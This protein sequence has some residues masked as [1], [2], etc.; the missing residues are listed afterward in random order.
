MLDNGL[1]MSPIPDDI[2]YVY[3]QNYNLLGASVEIFS[4]MYE[5]EIVT[6]ARGKEVFSFESIETSSIYQHLK[7]ENIISFG[8]RWF[9]IKYAQDVE[10]TKGLTKFTCYALWYELAEGLPRPLKHVATTVGSVAQD[11]IKDAGKWVQVVCPPDGANKSVRS[12][13]A[14]ENSMLWHLR[15]L[16]KQY[17]LEITFGYEELLEQEVRIVRTVV[18][19]Q[20]YT[21]SKVDFPLVVEENLKYVTRQEDSRNL[22]TAYKL[23]GKKEEGSQEPLTFASIN[24]GSDYLIDVSWFTARQMRPRYIAKSKSDERFKIKENLMSAARAYL[25]IYCRPLIG[26]EASAVL[27]KK[28]PDLHHTQ[29]IVDDHYS[30]IEWRKIS[31]RKIDYDDLSQS[32]L[33]FQDPRRDLMDLLNEDGEGVLAGE[34]ETESHVVIRYADDILGTNFNAESGKY[35]GVI[36]TTKHSNELVP[37]DFTWVKLQGPE[38][39]QGEQGS[40]GRDGVDGVAGKNGVGIADTSITYAVSVSGTQEPENGWSE[41]VPE[42]IK[43]RFLWTKTFWR[44]TDGAHE[45]GYSVA[46]IGQDGNTGKDGIAGKDGVGIAATEIMYASSNSSTI[47]PAGGWSTQV[48][49]VPQGHY[50]WTRTTWRYTDKT[51]ETG[52]SVSRNG[53]DGAKG[54]PGRDGVPGKN[55]LG[56]K[57]T[58]VMYGI[59]MNDT[60]QPGSWT[61]QVPAL[62]KGQYL[63]TRTIWTYTDNTNE[64]GYQKTY[65]PRDGNNGRDGIAGKDGVGIK[66][67]TITYAGSTSGT[68]PPTTNWTSN[69]PN[70]QPGFFLWTKTVWTYTDNTS[71]TG[72]SISKIGETGPRGLQ[73]LQGPQGLQ[74]IPG[75]TGRDGRSQYTHIAFSDSPNGKGFSHTDQGRAYIGQYQDFNSEH[76]KDPAAY[77]WTKW[78]GN[79]GAQ[80]IPGK[81]GADGKTNYFHIAYASSA[82]GSR[83]FSLEDNNQQYMGYYSDYEKADSRDRTKYR[84]FDRLANV[85]VGGRNLFLNS[86]FK[87]PLRDR[88]STYLLQDNASQTQGQL[89]LS[90]DTTNKFRGANTLKIVSTFNGKNTNQKATF[91]IGGSNRDGSV[92]EMSNKSVRFSFWAKS[93]KVGAVFIF[94]AGY[95]GN[96]NAVALTDQ[97]K[98]YS[99]EFIRNAPSNATA[100]LI[101]HLFTVATVWVAFPKVEVGT[102]STDFTEAPEDMEEELNNKADQKLTN[103]QLIALTEKAQLHD[104]ELKAKA[105]MEQLSNLEKAYKGRMKANEE[106]IKKSEADLILAASRIEATIQELGGLRELKKFV[107]SYM[108]SSNEGLIIGKND[109]S[110]TIKVSSD[111]ISMFSAGKEVMYLT[112]GVI[113][114]DNGIFTQSIQVGR[115]RTEQYSF[116]SDMNVIRYVG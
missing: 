14:K 40:P 80:G 68:V 44:Y 110:S 22:C 30:V 99:V 105:T 57:N 56:L 97:W 29:L 65:I 96:G 59:S 11:I 42:L 10:D 70:V 4:K 90:I 103:Q 66:S 58:S 62:I 102:I 71:E 39:P 13:T 85:Q 108:S 91:N 54:D 88:Y 79:D 15:Y 53:Q 47:A 60:V 52:Y 113:H 37:D 109:G 35:I 50:L 19:L 100:E 112:Q 107:D 17:N 49:T 75:A 33:T 9:R 89:E 106:A 81:P 8:G 7:V 45:T 16:A 21:E 67:T 31:S 101:L 28:I 55:G 87:R 25:D 34:L 48:P 94:R 95:R 23:T 2:V 18:F 51:T 6:R 77:R 114:I 41:Q 32:V 5:D 78:K 43:G 64:T 12:I 3:D 36:S 1:V 93:N 63:W 111:R 61:S 116:N 83:E 84:W 98:Y 73:G 20:P 92:T 27:Y 76:S 24:N 82:D 26:Y 104:A 72:Y 69:I 74:G 46:Y 115:F 38:G 86:L